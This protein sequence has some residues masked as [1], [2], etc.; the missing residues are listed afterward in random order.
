[1]LR[2]LVLIPHRDARNLFR[3]WSEG[4][5][6]AGLSG[7]WAF[8]WA[9]PLACLS[10]PL[11]PAELREAAVALRE[12][13]ARGDGKMRTGAAGLCPLPA[14]FSPPPPESGEMRP[15]ACGEWNGPALYGPRLEGGDPGQ[16]LRGAGAAKVLHCFSPLILGSALLEGP[17]ESPGL[18]EALPPPPETAFRV[19]ALA[20]MIYRR[21]DAGKGAS[22]FEWKTGKLRWLPSAGTGKT[23]RSGL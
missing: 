4:L 12:S 19:A 8:P 20:N 9:V 18:G 17:G 6:A 11:L 5:F 2:L 14:S 13:L 15:A 22:F 21:R 10:R 16:A 7:A 23:K 1:M 3:R